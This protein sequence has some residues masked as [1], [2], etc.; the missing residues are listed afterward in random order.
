MI[1]TG[2]PI[3]DAADR[4]DAAAKRER[5]AGAEAAQVCGWIGEMVGREAARMF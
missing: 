5:E 3:L 4:I 1:E 2:R